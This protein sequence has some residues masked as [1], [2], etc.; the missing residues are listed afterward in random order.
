MESVAPLL[1]G[2]KYTAA[3]EQAKYDKL[4]AATNCS[5]STNGTLQCLRDLPCEAINAALNGT[6]AGSFFPYVDGDLIQGSL[7]DQLESGAF[8]KVPIIAGTNSDECIFTAIGVNINTDAKFRSR[9][10]AYGSNSTVPFLEVL[11]PNIP[12][13][14][15]PEIWATPPAGRG[16][17][18]KRWAALSGGFTFVAPRRLTCQSWSKHNVTAYCY[19][20]NGN[21]ANLPGSTHFTEVA[22]VFYNLERMAFA[23]GADAVPAAYRNTA[24]AMSNMWVSFFTTHDPNEHGVSGNVE[25][26]RYDDGAGGYGQNFVFEVKRTS[27]IEY[28]NWRAA[29][30]AYLNSVFGSVYGK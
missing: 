5:A 12:G 18:T 19:R 1:L 26:P 21:V 30:I 27:S 23:G 28:D 17:Q 13:A 3:T 25:W 16:S 10:A 24:K 20:F 15:I 22:Y 6:A 11:Y 8:V 9:A 7:Y 4:V 2:S 14:G 29:G